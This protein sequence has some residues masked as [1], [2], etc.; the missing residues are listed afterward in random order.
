MSTS[1]FLEILLLEYNEKSHCS[2]SSSGTILARA[3]RHSCCP[4]CARQLT[5]CSDSSVRLAV[6]MKNT[7]ILS[8]SISSSETGWLEFQ[9]A[10][11]RTNTVP[12]KYLERASNRERKREEQRETERRHED[13]HSVVKST[14][15][16]PNRLSREHLI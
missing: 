4:L 10:T 15:C 9:S 14:K 5:K 3:N 12:W 7:G 1:I 16:C 11:L 8:C 6:M 13:R 2:L